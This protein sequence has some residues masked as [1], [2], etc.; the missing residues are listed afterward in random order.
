MNA[1]GRLQSQ[2]NPAGGALLGSALLT[3]ATFSV[4]SGQGSGLLLAVGILVVMGCLVALTTG[5]RAGS[6]GR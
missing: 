4:I 3:G 5:V 2:V 1:H 6:R